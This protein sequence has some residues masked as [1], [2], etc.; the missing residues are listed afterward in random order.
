MK[1]A[2]RMFHARVL[3]GNSCLDNR[4]F[5]ENL[6]DS[7]ASDGAIFFNRAVVMRCVT[8]HRKQDVTHD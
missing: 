5:T 8:F 6:E 2:V 3:F 4:Y 1:D 7:G